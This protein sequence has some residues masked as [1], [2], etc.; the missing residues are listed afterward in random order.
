[1]KKIVLAS[2]DVALVDDKDYEFVSRW[3]WKR[4]PQGYAS[5]SGYENGQFVTILM[6]RLI[7]DAKDGVEVHHVNGNKLDNRRANLQIIEPKEHRMEHVGPLI[8]S[9]KERQLYPD[10]K[11][12]ANC[13]KSFGVNPR[14]RK[15]NKCCSPE[16]AQTMRVRAALD[17]RRRDKLSHK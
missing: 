6:H 8:K 15:R 9:S 7:A 1:M 2:Q 3:K 10:Q 16:C 17:A 13:G 4:H 11:Q 5:R 12:C 14:K